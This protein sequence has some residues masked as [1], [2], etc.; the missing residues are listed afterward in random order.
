MKEHK[1]EE[2]ELVKNFLNRTFF[3]S[4]K[5]ENRDK[6]KYGNYNKLE[7]QINAI[8]NLKCKYCYYTRFGDQIYPKSISNPETYYIT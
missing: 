6:D 2:H 4:W 1:R 3:E 5:P 8:C 7:V